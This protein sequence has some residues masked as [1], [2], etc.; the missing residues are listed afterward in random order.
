MNLKPIYRRV[1]LK[2]SG[3]IF[4][5]SSV[6]G[7][8][9][10]IVEGVAL[11]IKKIVELS[12]EIAIVIGGGNFFRGEQSQNFKIS[13]IVGDTIGML[14]TAMNGLVVQDALNKL[15]LNVKLMSAIPLEGICDYYNLNRAIEFMNKGV[16]VIFLAGT[17][18]PLFTT[19]SAACLR[20]IEIQADIVLKGTK[21]DGVY[22]DDPLKN[23]DVIFYNQL[24][25]QEVLDRKLRIM[26]EAAFILARD[27]NLP[28]R[29]FNMNESGILFQILTG[30]RKGTLISNNLTS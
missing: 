11:E 10:I 18:N 5:G 4:R 29:I 15:S 25:Y 3:E 19:D 12:T 26:D 20:G 1:L 14:G 7:I 27:Y 17:G 9:P 16:I 6:Y 21:V 28:I 22:S 2:L 23:S 13:R 8:D 24:T 30:E